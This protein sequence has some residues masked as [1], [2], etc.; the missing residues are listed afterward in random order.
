MLPEIEKLLTLQDRDQR[1]RTL[2]IELAAI[3]EETALKQKQISTSA[4]RLEAAKTRLRAIEVEKKTLELEAESKRTAIAR[5]RTQQFETRKNEEF[6]AIGHEIE[7]A[8]R[9]IRTTEDRELEL[10]EEAE[11]LAPAV[12]EAERAHSEERGKLESQISDLASK[13]ENIEASIAELTASRAPLTEGIDEDE[14]DRYERI[15]KSKNG[16][17]IVELEGEVCTGCHVKV[18]TQTMLEVKSAKQVV[19]CPNC[20]RILYIQF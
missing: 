4:S 10:M 20:S 9:V 7:N 16:T 12:A 3:P 6:A 11:S 15:F 18:T 1:I 8:E 13:K 17:A 14:L 2:K 5:Y 19:H